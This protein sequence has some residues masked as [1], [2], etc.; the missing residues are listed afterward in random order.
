M[1]SGDTLCVFVP[2]NYEPP[3]TN[4]ALWGLRNQH[5]V[6]KF[7]DTTD[8]EAVWSSIMPR[9]YGGGGITAY[10]H[11]AMDTATANDVVWQGAFERIGDQQ[12]DID[13]DS[14][15]AFQSSGAIT[16]P[17]TAGLVDICTITFTNGAQMDSVAVGEGF[18]FKLRRDA[19]DTSATDNASGD[20]HLRFV[21]LKET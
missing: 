3:S 9:S 13:S 4:Y 8:W 11:Y 20:A 15:E 5:P 2:S 10:I 6:L 12:L 21:E 17:G 19:D 14:F 18:R 16:V 1:A 7:N